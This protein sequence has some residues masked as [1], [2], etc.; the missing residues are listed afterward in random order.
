M[1]S[2]HVGEV[3]H[4]AKFNRFHWIVLFW[5]A[6][7][8]VFDGYD[9][10]VY[11]SVVPLLMKEWKLSPIEAG[12]LGSYALFGMMLGAMIFGPLA[13]R[14]GRK[15][16]ILVCV[17]IFSLFTG[18]VGFATGP[19]QFGIFRFIAGLGLGGVMPN[20]VAMMSEFSPKKI[21]STMVSIM[22]SGYSLGGMLAAGLSIA[23]LPSFGWK[24]VFFVGAL[25]LLALP[26]MMKHLPE[27]A[28]FLLSKNQKDKVGQLLHQVDP[29]YVYQSGD[30]YIVE[31]PQKKSGSPL[32]KLFEN[33]RSLST[34]MFWIAFFM[35]LLMIY[36][37]NTWLP[38]L[39]AE[40]GYP[41]GSSLTFLFVLNFGAIFGAV[42]GGWMADHWSPK[43]VLVLFYLLAGISL[44]LLGFKSNTFVLYVL[45]AI[46]GAA[47]IGTQII[48]NAFV[49]VYY[50]TLMRSTAIGWA[51]G[52]GRI[53]AI[54]GPTMGGILLSMKLPFQYNFLAFAIPGFIAAFTIM[55]I[56]EKY[57]NY[58][59]VTN[60]LPS[61]NEENGVH[62]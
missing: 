38:K 62:I 5:C 28:E 32:V 43:K 25:P 59:Q 39:M 18:V 56:Q 4:E 51:L 10:V 15:K 11:G 49:S 58:N 9:L 53:G 55:F 19:M 40:A 23:L 47:T 1:R 29:T 33:G 36:G 8:I 60:K 27:T 16:V 26:L 7:T 24:S 22:F 35:C 21:K 17:A 54:V 20:A 61:N 57:A 2:I 41:L 42:I 48:A 30:E 31:L 50:P 37:L 14:I 3:I 34:V 46:A 12:A 44:T 6:F 45:V 52:V 13:D